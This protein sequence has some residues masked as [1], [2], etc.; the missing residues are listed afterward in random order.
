MFLDGIE[1]FF[2][3]Q[4]SMWHST[5][6]FSSILDLL[7]WQ[8]KLGY[9]CKNFKLLLIFCFSMESSHFWPSFLRDPLYKT[10]FFEF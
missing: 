7:P 6:R 5:K 3:H 1:P 10:L 9:F 8:Q 4:F 2:G